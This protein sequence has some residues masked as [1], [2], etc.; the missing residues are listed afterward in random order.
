MYSRSQNENTTF[1]TRCLYC[2]MTIAS[3]VE[4]SAE[5]DGLEARHMC[6]EKALAQMLAKEQSTKPGL[7]RV[8]SHLSFGGD[9]DA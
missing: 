2:F 9:G 7:H 1:N 8:P 5:L 6:P 4:S 3:E